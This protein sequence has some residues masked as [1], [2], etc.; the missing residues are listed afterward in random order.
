MTTEEE[1]DEFINEK[2]YDYNPDEYK[3][4]DIDGKRIRSSIGNW[5][6]IWSWK[7]CKTRDSYWFK[8]K[9]WLH[10][11]KADGYKSYR[12]T[13]NSV[14]CIMSRVLFKL[15]NPNWDITDT[16]HMNEI[17]HKN[18]NSLDNRIENLRVLTHQQNQCN[19]T[20]RGTTQ[21]PN[22]KWQAQIMY[23]GICKSKQPFDTEPEAH[24]QYLI[25]KK[26]FHSIP[27]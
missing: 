11:N 9:P 21:R 26:E 27:E 20:F 6:D 19:R 23:N 18:Q 1:E 13:I 16:S 22:G 8:M 25:W 2:N 24:D 3:Y 5:G 14:P 4:G 10:T 17:D 12:V 15:Y 7:K